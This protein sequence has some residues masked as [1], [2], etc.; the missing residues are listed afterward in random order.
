MCVL[1]VCVNFQAHEFYPEHWNIACYSSILLLMDEQREG[2]RLRER[3]GV[4]N[5]EMTR[6]RRRERERDRKT[7]RERKKEWK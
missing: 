3:E 4:R 6:E 2:E 7:G 5:I 1:C